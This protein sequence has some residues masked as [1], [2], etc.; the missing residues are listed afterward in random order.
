MCWC[1]CVIQD[2]QYSTPVSEIRSAALHA[3]R[4]QR[5]N[6]GAAYYLHNMDIC[7]VCAC[8]TDNFR[9]LVRNSINPDTSV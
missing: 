1:G 4:I 7:P 6:L 2:R 8:E 5:E 3:D 9:S